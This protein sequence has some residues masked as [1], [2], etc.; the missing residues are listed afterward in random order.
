MYRIGKL[1]K[2]LTI[3]VIFMFRGYFGHFLGLEGILVIFE[4]W[5]LFW[6][7]YLFIFFIL[8]FGDIL[9]IL[10]V[11]EPIVPCAHTALE[12]ARPNIYS[13]IYKLRKKGLGPISNLRVREYPRTISKRRD[14]ITLRGE[15]KSACKEFDYIRGR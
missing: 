4:F 6:F 14:K 2:S 12:E 15:V 13:H 11:W 1:R 5:G 3:L 9:N 10:E 8:G 7:F